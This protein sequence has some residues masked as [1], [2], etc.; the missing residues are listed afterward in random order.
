MSVLEL[1]QAIL[2]RFFILSGMVVLFGCYDQPRQEQSVPSSVSAREQSSLD[3]GGKGGL[4][5]ASLGT[6]DQKGTVQEL[7]GAERIVRTEAVIREL[8]P[9]L[10]AL[11]RAVED[12]LLPGPFTRPFFAQ[13][14]Q[15]SDLDGF[16]IELNQHRS[17]PVKSFVI[18]PQT[19]RQVDRAEIELWK[20]MLSR[21]SVWEYANFSI[22]RGR[23]VE[24]DRFAASVGFQGAFYDTEENYFAVN[25]KL[26]VNWHFESQWRI[27]RFDVQE[28]TGIFAATTLFQDAPAFPRLGD[29]RNAKR[30][31]HEERVIEM[32]A[33]GMTEVEKPEYVPYFRAST[34]TMHPGIAVADVNGDGYDDVYVAVRWGRNK[35]FLNQGDG[36]FRNAASELGVDINGVSTSAVFADFDNDG[37]QDLFVGRSLERAVYLRNE[38]SRFVDRTLE[39]CDCEMPFLATSISVVDH[40]RDGLLDVYICTYGIPGQELRFTDQGRSKFLSAE[41]DAELLRRRDLEKPSDRWVNLTGPPNLLLENVGGRFKRADQVGDLALWRNS[42]QSVWSDIDDDG[43]ADVYIANDFAPD[44]LLR[45]DGAAGF[46]DITAKWGDFAM[47]GYGMG[48][49]FGDFNEDGRQDLYVSNMYSKAGMRVVGLAGN[50]DPRIQVSA[51]G[52]RLYQHTGAGFDLV[53]GRDDAFAAVTNAGWSWGGQFADLDND[54]YLDLYVTSGYLTAPQV[55]SEDRDL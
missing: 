55:I 7:N 4:V 47:Q 33:K 2:R 31:M 21:A 38:G 11:S 36:T 46:V 24:D 14:V 37:D 17:L 42:F 26:K 35:M 43:D 1:A 20:E 54:G 12:R 25:V 45:N 48:A 28:A 49:A 51:N 18:S 16:E 15:I 52:N 30:S 23:F 34:L 32:Y 13:T 19:S 41:Q 10:T 5:V 50:V 29:R 22:I 39:L 3:E 8:R 27:D 9:G 40:N 53:S 44:N 6:E